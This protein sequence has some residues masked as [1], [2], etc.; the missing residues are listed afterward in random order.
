MY[1]DALSS[2]NGY[3]QEAYRANLKTEVVLTEGPIIVV[4][5]AY[6][7]F[8]LA[9]TNFDQNACWIIKN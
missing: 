5:D 8:R 7:K 3:K 6:P 1:V 2:S 9:Q 4:T